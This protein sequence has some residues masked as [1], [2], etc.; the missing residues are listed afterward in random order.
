MKSERPLITHAESLVFY[1]L[2]NKVL[3]NNM[4]A[5]ISAL[6]KIV[7]RVQKKQQKTMRSRTNESQTT[8]QLDFYLF[9][10]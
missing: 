2:T 1:P 7:K 5:Y 9:K 8:L 6:L 3:G 4:K 10:K